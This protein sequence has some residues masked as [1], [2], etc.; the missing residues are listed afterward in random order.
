MMSFDDLEDWGYRDAY[1]SDLS[2]HEAAL[3]MLADNGWWN[4][5]LEAL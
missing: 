4:E 5:E 1:D 2:P 3:E